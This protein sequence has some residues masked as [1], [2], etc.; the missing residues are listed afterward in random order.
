MPDPYSLTPS[1]NTLNSEIGMANPDAVM[2][3]E[4][5][6]RG[7]DP[8]FGYIGNIIVKRYARVLPELANMLS[9]YYGDVL[10]QKTMPS[11]SDIVSRFVNAISTPGSTIESIMGLPAP[12]G[13]PGMPISLRD[14]ARMG[15]MT[16][17]GKRYLVDLGRQS[18][19]WLSNFATFLDMLSGYTPAYM[20]A[21]QSLRDIKSRRYWED[22]LTQGRQE[23]PVSDI[24][25]L[26]LR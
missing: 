2:A 3:S 20:R 12:Q 22:F 13:D 14:A 17:K 1:G 9:F 7:Y 6:R 4:L 24:I 15:L 11:F 5:R 23:I 18:E 19:D 8:D 16:E 21:S 25:D 26:Y 10:G